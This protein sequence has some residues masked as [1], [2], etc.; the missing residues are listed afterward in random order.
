VREGGGPGEGMASVLNVLLHK[1][2]R[3]E[4][5]PHKLP[6][7]PPRLCSSVIHPY[8]YAPTHTNKHVYLGAPPQD[9]P[10][11]EGRGDKLLIPRGVELGEPRAVDVA[12]VEGLL[13]RRVHLV[14]QVAV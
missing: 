7:A 6:A 3:S 14:E 1:G 2:L 4:N 13:S 5:V 11:T 9:P 12:E 8:A 10:V